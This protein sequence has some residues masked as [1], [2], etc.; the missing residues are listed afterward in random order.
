MAAPEVPHRGVEPV[1]SVMLRSRLAT[2]RARLLPRPAAGRRDL[3]SAPAALVVDVEPAAGAASARRR[4]SRAALGHRASVPRRP[5]RCQ[6]RPHRPQSGAFASVRAPLTAP[7]TVFGAFIFGRATPPLTSA[8]TSVQACGRIS[9]PSNATNAST[10]KTATPGQR[11]PR[12][13]ALPHNPPK[14][15]HELPERSPAR[16]RNGNHPPHR[17]GHHQAEPEPTPASPGGPPP[18]VRTAASKPAR[19]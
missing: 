6:H 11:A 19:P 5:E 3:G 15:R 16:P 8:G 10:P 14:H 12:P 2:D 13:K 7:E 9:D 1:E 4:P 17:H 18:R